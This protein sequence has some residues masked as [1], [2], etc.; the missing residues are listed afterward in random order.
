MSPAK[1]LTANLAIA[2]GVIAGMALS[3][4]TPSLAQDMPSYEPSQNGAVFQPGY[5]D[6]NGD[7]RTGYRAPRDRGR[8]QA[9]GRSNRVGGAVGNRGGAPF[10]DPPGSD[11]QTQGN[12][13]DDMGCP[14]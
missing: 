4:T 7:P 8:A 11:F 6:Q 5:T 9:S 14:C 3:V 10:D 2:I 13:R 1:K 12:D